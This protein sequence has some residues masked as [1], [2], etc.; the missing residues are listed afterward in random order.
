MA[1]W[2]TLVDRASKHTTATFKQA[3]SFILA[4]AAAY[5]LDSIF[6]EKAERVTYSEDGIALASIMPM[7]DVRLVDLPTVPTTSDK[8]HV[9][10]NW[11][12]VTHVDRDGNGNAKVYLTRVANE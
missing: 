4:G 11:Y 5:P 3:C 9:A 10:G 12:Q 2:R 7:V 6:D 8:V 1:S